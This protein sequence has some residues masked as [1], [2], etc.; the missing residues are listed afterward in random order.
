M[1]EFFEKVKTDE[2]VDSLQHARQAVR[3]MA[4]GIMP[5]QSLATAAAHALRSSVVMRADDTPTGDSRMVNQVIGAIRLGVAPSQE[6]CLFADRHL[7]NLIERLTQGNV[8][9]SSER[10]RQR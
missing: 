5:A 8:E 1:V 2:A 3:L 9:Q 4:Q 10:P 7:A 6:N